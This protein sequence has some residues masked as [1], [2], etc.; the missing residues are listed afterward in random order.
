MDNRVAHTSI[1][2]YN[3]STNLSIQILI[4]IIKCR[5]VLIVFENK[6][7]FTNIFVF[8]S[9]CLI[10]TIHNFY[11]LLIPGLRCKNC[12]VLKNPIPS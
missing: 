5:F 9:I 3:L 1:H 2:M 4:V 8:I 11:N 7:Y 6:H 10:Y 12:A